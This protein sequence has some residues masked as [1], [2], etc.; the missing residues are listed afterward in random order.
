MFLEGHGEPGTE[1]RDRTGFSLAKE[2]LVKQGYEIRTLSLLTQ[3]AVP[4]QYSHP[5]DCR[6]A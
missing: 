6:S 3:T 1:N 5:G 2:I 4:D